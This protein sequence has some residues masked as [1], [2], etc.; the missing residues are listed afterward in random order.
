MQRV[1]THRNDLLW[2]A[3]G[4]IDPIALGAA[5][6]VLCGSTLFA[7]TVILL[8]KGGDLVGP[9]LA[10]AGQY[11]VG[12]TVTP[13]GSLIGAAY[14]FLFGFVVGWL[15]A[16]L[17]NL[18]LQVYLHTIRLTSRLSAVHDVFDPQ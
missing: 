2:K 8:L 18:C 15:A 14:G 4:R 3:F 6:G 11:F 7:A 16:I 9:R 12:Y 13:F 10:L 17:R 5:I 1:A